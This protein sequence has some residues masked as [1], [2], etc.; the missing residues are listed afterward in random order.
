MLK[1]DGAVVTFTW[2]KNGNM[3][4]RSDG[5]SYSWDVGNRLSKVVN[6]NGTTQFIYDGDGNRTGKIFNDIRT[7]YLWDRVLIVP[8]IIG[9]N[10]ESQGAKFVH[11]DGHLSMSNMENSWAYVH[12]DAIGSLRTLS[13]ESRDLFETYKYRAFG[14]MNLVTGQRVSDFGFTGHQFDQETAILYMKG[15]YYRS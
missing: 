6:D 1:S 10:M 12:S 4:S 13:T 7:V 9:Q 14:S 15:R 5:T 8:L 3:L 11:A 2:D